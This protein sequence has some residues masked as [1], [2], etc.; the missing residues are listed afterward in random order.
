MTITA[1]PV[2]NRTDA[3]F[4]A[5]VDTFF[6]TEL[7]QF[8][9]EAEAA[10]VEINANTATAGAAAVSAANQVTLATIQAQAAAGSALVAGAIVWVSGTTYA[11]GDARYSPINLQTYRSATVH[12][13]TIDPSLDDVNWVQVSPAMVDQ[14]QQPLN[15]SPTNATVN[16]KETPVLT[17]GTFYSL[18]GT[19]LSKSRFQISTVSNFASV[20]HDSG[21]ITGSLTYIVPAGILQ[22]GALTY[23]WRVQHST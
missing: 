3:T 18:Y 16:V 13:S 10:R 14:V 5:D 21:E 11:V 2:L 23:Y 19:P 20:L 7:P 6:G 15:L 8:S 4:K 12:T 1:L 17:S 9:V 22:Q